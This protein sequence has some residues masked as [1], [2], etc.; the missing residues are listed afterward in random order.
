[1]AILVASGDN[2]TGN[3]NRVVSTKRGRGPKT[4]EQVQLNQGQL[5]L[6]SRNGPISAI[7]P[8]DEVG[9]RQVWM[10]LYH[11]DL[12]RREVRSELSLP[13]SMGEDSRPDGWQ[14][15]IVLEA[16]PFDDD[17]SYPIDDTPLWPDIDVPVEKRG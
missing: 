17:M 5:D 7:G 6:F 15:R 12:R 10:L 14:E 3:Q 9:K 16:I 11:H 13:F 8:I 4:S 2:G 1:M